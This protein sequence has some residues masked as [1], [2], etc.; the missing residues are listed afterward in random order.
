MKKTIL[1]VEDNNEM[2]RLEVEALEG[3]GYETLEAANAKDG[4]ALSLEKKPDLILMDIRLPSK[5]R[6]IG[7]ARIV[8]NNEDTSHIPIIFVTAYAMGKETNE[9]KNIPNCGY[10]TKPFEIQ[11]LLDE[12]EQFLEKAS[13]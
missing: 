12:V 10:L 9:V 7:A 8:R 5:K 1:V 2:R 13:G 11:A 6:G 3:A 4:I